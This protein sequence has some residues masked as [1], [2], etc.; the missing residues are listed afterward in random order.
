MTAD[1]VPHVNMDTIGLP[2]S[3]AAVSCARCL[4]GAHA[5]NSARHVAISV[6]G[7]SDDMRD[8][9]RDVGHEGLRRP[10]IGRGG[11]FRA[12]RERPR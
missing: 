4:D 1:P 10:S 6:I 8:A 2:P 3:A 7:V 9:S 11:T 12:G 5:C